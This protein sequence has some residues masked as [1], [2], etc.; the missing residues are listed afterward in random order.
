MAATP[1]SP[2]VVELDG[3]F[4][5]RM[6]HTRGVRLH[7]VENVVAGGVSSDAGPLVLLIHGAF[8]GWFDFK[9]ALAPLAAHGVHAAALDLRGYGMSDKP[10]TR[11]GDLKQILGGDVAGAIRT[12]GHTSAVLVGADT[13]AVVAQAAARRNPDLVHHVIALPTSR[14]LTAA[15]ARLRFPLLSD[16]TL[17]NVWRA[18]FT[19]DTTD[20][21]HGTARFEEFLQLRLTA[22]RIDNAL[23]HIVETN[24]LR[25]RRPIPTDLPELGGSRLPHI[26]DPEGFA[27]AVARHLS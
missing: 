22:R 24:R 9:D 20:T 19:A 25:P 17:D 27:A 3:A 18:N 4:T 14:G 2:S 16:R 10:L 21:F 1:L 6:L 11:A 8:G 15:L 13:G 12:L 7:A 23:P 5:H 26:E